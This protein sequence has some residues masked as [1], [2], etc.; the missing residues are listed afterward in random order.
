MICKN[1]IWFRI[2][3]TWVSIYG[4]SSTHILFNPEELQRNNVPM[5][6]CDSDEGS[7]EGIDHGED[8]EEC[9]F[10]GFPLQVSHPDQSHHDHLNI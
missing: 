2:D 8:Q 1:Q 3:I 9:G 5:L 6:N 10:R 4:T 7:E